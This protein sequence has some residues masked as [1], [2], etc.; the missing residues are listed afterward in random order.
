[1]RRLPDAFLSYIAFSEL[2][3]RDFGDPK[4]AALFHSKGEPCMGTA[5]QPA[6]L[7]QTVEARHP[8]SYNVKN[9][10]FRNRFWY[11]IGCIAKVSIGSV[12]TF[13]ASLTSTAIARDGSSTTSASTYVPQSA[14]RLRDCLAQFSVL[15]DF[16]PTA[17]RAPCFTKERR[18]TSLLTRSG[19]VLVLSV[20]ASAMMEQDLWSALASLRPPELS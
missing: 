7:N 16:V 5:E 4:T 3:K 12:T 19:G 9:V 17:G 20:K 15:R 2:V 8:A 11:V 10:L 18:F 13:K 14:F 1:L 6:E